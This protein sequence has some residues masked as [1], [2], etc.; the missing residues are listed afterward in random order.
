VK[1]SRR[2]IL[3]VARKE[4][5]DLRRNGNVVYAMAIL[6][7]V[8]AVE[9]LIEAFRVSARAAVLLHQEHTLIYMLAIPTMVPAALAS[10]SIVGERIQ[11]TLEPLLA[12]PLLESELVLGK[13]LAV[14]VPSVAVSYFLFGIYIAILELFAAPAVT[15]AVVQVPEVVVQVIFTPL[16]VVWSTWLAMAIS[17]RSRDVRAASQASIVASL[18]TV[19]VSLLIAFNVIPADLKVALGFGLGLFVVDRV[20]WRVVTALVDRERLVSSSR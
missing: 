14:F 11:G 19:A 16:L 5:S 13:A 15:A 10:Y 6:P 12:A 3:G 20:G 8:F 7:A 18:P 17:S 4:V 9:P 1:L 2:R